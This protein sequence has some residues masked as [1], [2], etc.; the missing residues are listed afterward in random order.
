MKTLAWRLRWQPFGAN[1]DQKLCARRITE[2]ML[3][4]WSGGWPYLVIPRCGDDTSAAPR[5]R[6]L[7]LRETSDRNRC[8]SVDSIYQ[9]SSELDHHKYNNGLAH[10]ITNG[11][12]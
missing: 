7:N 11:L 3:G 2:V 6:R 9:Q 12:V 1:A 8:A 5:P 10:V 4:V